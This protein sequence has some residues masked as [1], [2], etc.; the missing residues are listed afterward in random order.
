M[1]A[2]VNPSH[3]GKTD[4]AAYVSAAGTDWYTD[5]DGSKPTLRAHA[6]G[7]LRTI[8]GTA[9]VDEKIQANPCRIRSAGNAKRARNIKPATLSELEAIA[10]ALPAKYRPMLL[11]SAWCALRFGEGKR[12]RR[13]AQ[14]ADGRVVLEGGASQGGL[15]RASA[16]GS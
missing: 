1:S 9:V 3:E 4:R 11:L 10:A 14:D 2:R 13:G 16:S 5:L 12:G 7:L 6:Y 8:M 15:R